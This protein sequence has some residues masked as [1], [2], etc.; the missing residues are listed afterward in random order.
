[1]SAGGPLDGVKVVEIGVAMAGPFCAMMLADYGA[2]GRQDRARR[3]GRRQPRLA[4][5]LPRRAR[6]LLRL[7]QPQQAERRPRPEERRGRRG[8]PAAD[9]RGRRRGGQ[10]PCRRARPRRARLRRAVGDEPAA[11]LLLDQRLRR[12]RAPERRAG[13]RP[14][15][16]GLLRRHE[17]HRGGRRRP[18]E[19]GPV[20]RGPRRGDAR[21]DGRADGAR[22]AAPHRARA[23][24]GDL[25][26]RGPARDAVLP[27][28]A[29]LLERRGAGAER[30]RRPRQPDLPGVQGLRRLDRHLRLQ[31][32]DVARPVR[33]ARAAGMG[34]RPA[35]PRRAA[36]CRQP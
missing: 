34:R 1:M 21:S 30:Q 15:H 13:E 28:D 23:A 18:R 14:V 33:R 2:R 5:L 27:P 7:R 12:D 32:P 19:D 17:H 22:G 29:V 9:R 11:D 8:R 26:A 36:A 35:L 4:P 24:R 6:P 10:L 20:G 3:R 25:A 31:R 16:A